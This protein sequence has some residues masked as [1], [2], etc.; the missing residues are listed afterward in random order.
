M[1][2]VQMILVT[3]EGYPEYGSPHIFDNFPAQT[4]DTNAAKQISGNLKLT[5]TS[6]RNNNTTIRLT[7]AYCPIVRSGGVSV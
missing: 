5:E 6:F 1:A 7:P 3:A 4:E 2:T